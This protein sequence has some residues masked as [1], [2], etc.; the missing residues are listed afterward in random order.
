MSSLFKI[1]ILFYVFT[2]MYPLRHLDVTTI[3]LLTYE[4]VVFVTYIHVPPYHT[5]C[6]IRCKEL[7]SLGLCEK[8]PA[9]G[10]RSAEHFCLLLLIYLPLRSGTNVTLKRGVQLKT[11]MS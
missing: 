6:C 1:F 11:G 10:A 2:E 4:E 9:P 8:P 5:F 3:K 7:P